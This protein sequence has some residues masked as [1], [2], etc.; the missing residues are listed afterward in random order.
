MKKK[1]SILSVFILLSL[2]LSAAIT[3]RPVGKID[4]VNASLNEVVISIPGAAEKYQMGDKLAVV[5]GGEEVVMTVIF[6]MMTVARAK[7]LSKYRGYTKRLKKGMPVYRFS[8]REKFTVKFYRSYDRDYL[9]RYR[10]VRFIDEID[11]GKLKSES[12][13]F[14]VEYDS[15]GLIVKTAEYKKQQKTVVDYY[16]G[17]VIIK[18][19]W[20]RP[21]GR[22]LEKL[23]VYDYY[24]NMTYRET[25]EYDYIHKTKKIVSYAENGQ[26]L[27]TE[28]GPL[29]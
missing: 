15:K 10:K 29:K 20:Y 4:K 9:N 5:I 17:D 23:N 1:I 21:G 11:V 27:K 14:R 6:P 2:S 18:K 26:V 24:E 16:K 22:K 12:Y 25:G 19:E 28:K 7:V 3:G 8:A 13:Y